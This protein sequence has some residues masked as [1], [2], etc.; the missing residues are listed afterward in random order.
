MNVDNIGK[1]QVILK[2][3]LFLTG[4]FLKN[5]A[6]MQEVTNKKKHPVIMFKAG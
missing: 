5:H 2:I 1:V 4:N 6:L 3:V